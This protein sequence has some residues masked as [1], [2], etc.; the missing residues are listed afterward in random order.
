M[1]FKPNKAS[2][3]IEVEGVDVDTKIAYI[4]NQAFTF[5]PGEPILSFINRAHGDDSIPTLCDA[6]NLKPYG[7]CRVCSVDVALEENGNA[8]AQASCH[9]PV[10]E[11]SYIYP[12]SDRIKSLRKNIIE[13]IY[14]SPT[15][16]CAFFCC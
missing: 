8:R 6:P 14:R 13:N 5:V 9:T 4:D 15:G 1:M 7:S 2:E 12:H 16:G 3:S 11:N 10:L